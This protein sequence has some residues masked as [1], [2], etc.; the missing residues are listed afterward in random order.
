MRKLVVSFCLILSVF[1]NGL[2]AD[3][4]STGEHRNI[5]QRFGDS[6]AQA[7]YKL[8]W[9]TAA[10]EDIKVLETNRVSNGYIVLAQFY[11]KSNLCVAGSCPLS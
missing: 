6:T 11:G 1:L 10:Y 4:V 8:A 2:Y 5:I 7:I 3:S 9:P